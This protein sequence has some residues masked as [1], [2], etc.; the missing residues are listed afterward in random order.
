MGP[1]RVDLKSQSIA[2][3]WTVQVSLFGTSEVLVEGAIHALPFKTAKIAAV[4]F[5]VRYLNEIMAESAA[6]TDYMA[7]LNQDPDR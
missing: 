4:A 1:F 5:F 2:H 6:L 3:N 7:T